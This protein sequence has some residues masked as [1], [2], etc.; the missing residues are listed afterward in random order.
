MSRQTSALSSI[1]RQRTRRGRTPVPPAPLGSLT[2]REHR[3]AEQCRACDSSSVTQLSMQLT[4]GTPVVF[5]SCHRCEHRTWQHH[6][7]ELSVD[8]VLERTRKP[9]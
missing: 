3:L 7:S 5:V 2:Q 8:T 4:D 6:G 1:P 9:A